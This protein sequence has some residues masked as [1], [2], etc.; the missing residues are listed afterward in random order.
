M[1][2]LESWQLAL[3]GAVFVWS[4]FA[5]AGLGFGGTALSLPFLLLIHNEPLLFLPIV[6]VQVVL[7]AGL[8][9]AERWLQARRGTLDAGEGGVDWPYLWRAMGVLIVPKLAG[10]A[11]LLL[12]PPRLMGAIIFV[13]VAIYSL[14]YLLNRPFRS[15][16]P[17]L[18]R[19]FLALGGY[20]SG[21]SL[22][23]APLIIA[24]FTTHV[25]R[26][27]LRDTLFAMWFL[28][29]LI[30]IAAFLWVGVNM[31]WAAQL[32]LLPCAALGHVLGLR[33]H[34]FLLRAD[35]TLFMRVIGGVML[36]TSLLG[37]L[38]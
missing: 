11:G 18:D 14:S 16:N 4:G 19:L 36:A 27:Q 7:F 32:W 20:F 26:N 25:A 6:A 2:V 33:F 15:T 30:K 5:R 12:L 1:D 17:W 8:L 23:G 38:R 21:T 22:V 9:G 37:L 29:V 34:R 13:I 24:V 10:V 35:E 28:L 3:I 31:Q